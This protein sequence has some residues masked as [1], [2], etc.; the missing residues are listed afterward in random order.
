MKTL[1]PYLLRL[2]GLT[3]ALA[4]IGAALFLTVLKPWYLQVF[5]W[6]LGFMSLITLTEHYILS[7]SLAG[8][9]NRF[10][11][12]F[13]GASALKLLLILLVMVVYLL[14]RKETV[15]P[16]VAG[17]FVLYFAFTWFEV[18]ILLKQVQGKV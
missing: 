13:M 9:P 12:V 8:R 11:Q 1:F 4:I 10:T 16:F 18:R 6:M 14:L 7:K 15:L 3:M 17:I 5:P 2:S